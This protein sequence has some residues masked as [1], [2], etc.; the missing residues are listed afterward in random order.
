MPPKTSKTR[1]RVASGEST[2]N[3]TS[4]VFNYFGSLCDGQLSTG[5]GNFGL[6]G[7]GIGNFGLTRTGI[8]RDVDLAGTGIG[9]GRDCSSKIAKFVKLMQVLFL[10]LKLIEIP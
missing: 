5:I 4:L 9:D 6:T 2:S 8:G 7:T 3:R 1:V 10:T